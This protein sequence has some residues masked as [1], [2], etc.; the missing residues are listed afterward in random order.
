M[1]PTCW[2][3]EVLMAETADAVAA[4]DAL[5]REEACNPGNARTLFAAL[6]KTGDDK[7][8]QAIKQVMV[9]LDA[10]PEAADAPFS[11]LYETLPFRMVYEMKLNRMERVGQTAA[12]YRAA[13]ARQWN[14]QTGRHDVPLQ[15]DA[16]FLLALTE[17]IAACS[18]Q[19]YEH[20]R[21]LVDIYRATLRGV[22]SVLAEA[23]PQTLAMVTWA[24]L[25][26]VRQG[27]IDPE[28]YLPT[29]QRAMAALRAAGE[30]CMADKL[31]EGLGGIA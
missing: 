3:N 12:M 16:W 14:P 6:E 17:G 24:L 21:A 13:H 29:A 26:G 30:V 5:I 19:L 15:E 22:L 31:Q 23:D 8:C 11:V 20:W 7:Y 2:I 28:R 25:D 1:N 4:A 9:Q 27:L 18:D 10:Q